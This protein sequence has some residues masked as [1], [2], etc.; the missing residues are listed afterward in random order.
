MELFIWLWA[1]DRK[2]FCDLKPG[3]SSFVYLWLLPVAIGTMTLCFAYFSQATDSRD[4][5]ACFK[6]DFVAE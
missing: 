2:L 3:Y 5:R 1:Y 6:D 4:M